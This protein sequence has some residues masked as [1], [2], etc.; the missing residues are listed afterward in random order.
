MLQTG[1]VISMAVPSSYN[2]VTQ[3]KA[4]RDHIGWAW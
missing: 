4:L 3:D 1:P 2:D